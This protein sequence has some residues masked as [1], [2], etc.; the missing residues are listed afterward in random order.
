M[1]TV[2]LVKA[3]A[4]LH[5][6]EW[7]VGSGEEA[8]GFIWEKAEICVFRASGLD[9]KAPEREQ[10]RHKGTLGSISTVENSGA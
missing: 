5:T 8:E 6:T 2:S 3:L 4:L 1:P 7:E 9:A 10:R